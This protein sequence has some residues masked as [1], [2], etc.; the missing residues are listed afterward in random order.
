MCEGG[1]DTY[2]DANHVGHEQG[3]AG[4]IQ[5]KRKTGV[6]RHGGKREGGRGRERPM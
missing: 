2:V 4:R 6:V 5:D 1:S 3:I